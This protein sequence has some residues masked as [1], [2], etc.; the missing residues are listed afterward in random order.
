[1]CGVFVQTMPWVLEIDG[2]GR[3]VQHDPDGAGVLR[4]EHP[5]HR[6]HEGVLL[7]GKEC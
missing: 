7:G 5:G 1:M 3:G 2:A 6:C 4:D